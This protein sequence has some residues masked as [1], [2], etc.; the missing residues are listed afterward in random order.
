[1]LIATDHHSG[2]A[3]WIVI[4][5]FVVVFVVAEVMGYRV[6][7]KYRLNVDVQ[8]GSTERHTVHFFRNP[9]TGRVRIAIDGDPVQSRIEWLGIKLVRNYE[10]SVGQ[11]ETHT[12]TFVKTRKLFFAGYRKQT[13]VAYVDGVEVPAIAPL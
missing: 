9:F 12:V 6:S 13:V 1:M 10:V 11:V 5:V 8:V 3:V 4:G 2:T 7:K